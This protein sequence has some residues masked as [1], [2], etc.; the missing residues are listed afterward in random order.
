MP[1]SQSRFLSLLA[2][3]GRVLVLTLGVMLLSVSTGAHL[4]PPTIT[5]DHMRLINDRA[6]AVATIWQEAR[7]L[8]YQGKLNVASAI[9]NRMAA[10]Y[11]SDGTIPGTVLRAFQFSGWNAKD[12]NRFPSVNIDDSNPV[13]AECAKAW[14]ESE[15][16]DSVNGAVLY[17]AKSMGNAPDWALP[18]NSKI[19]AQDN[20][21]I[22]LVPKAL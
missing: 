17:Y 1:D 3:P 19:V 14:D 2:Q 10:K 11:S 13:V 4:S 22:F 18:S 5:E 6:L 12:P 21:H 7:G 16:S 8:N 20:G 15:H 9:R